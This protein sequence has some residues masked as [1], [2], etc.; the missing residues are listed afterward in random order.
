MTALAVLAGI[1]AVYMSLWFGVSQIVKR[2]DVADIAWGLGFG[3]MAWSAAALAGLSPK[4][5][6][7]NCLVT[8]WG[9]RLAGYIFWRNRRKKE[10][11]RYQKWRQDWGRWFFIRSY[12]QVYLLQGALL[13]LI[14]QPVIFINFAGGKIGWWDWMGAAVWAVG[15]GLETIADSQLAG[16]V[17]DPRNKGKLMTVGLWRYSRHPNY[18]GEVSLWWGIFLLALGLPGG[19][20][21][22]VGPLAIT[23][24]ILWVSGVPL[25]EK[26]YAGRPDWEKYKQTTSL[27]LPCPPR[28]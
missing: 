18:F 26:K 11:Y 16:F 15:F 21:T 27:F 28:R 3:L 5:L 24:L 8:I 14:A 9:L 17:N 4:G 10:D 19:W 22:A 7:V 2:N 1:L 13:F 20:R 12:L 23:V 6:L 25:L